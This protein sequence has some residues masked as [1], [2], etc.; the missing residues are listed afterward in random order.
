MRYVHG[1]CAFSFPFFKH[2]TFLNY[3]KFIINGV[4]FK[5]T[6]YA[7]I[8]SEEY[9]FGYN[10]KSVV[11]ISEC[12][13]F[14]L[15]GLSIGAIALDNND[16]CKKCKSILTV[17][18]LYA[19]KPEYLEKEMKEIIS[20]LISETQFKDFIF[21][22]REQLKENE[23]F[24]EVFLKYCNNCKV[25]YLEYKYMKC[26][27]K[28]NNNINNDIEWVEDKDKYKRIKID[29]DKYCDLTKIKI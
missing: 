28:K 3:L 12:V 15:G 6:Y 22:D 9:H 10:F 24:I 23:S 13:G 20:S 27:D 1:V 29:S 2:F 26:I 11:F 4:S 25:V 5:A 17:R 19:F 21:K 8:L 14:C 7:G 16:N 18:R